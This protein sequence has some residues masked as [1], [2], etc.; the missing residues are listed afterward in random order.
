MQSI[1]QVFNVA[2]TKLTS[3]IEEKDFR[4]ESHRVFEEERRRRDLELQVWDEERRQRERDLLHQ[5][6]EARAMAAEE[7]MR[8]RELERTETSYL[9]D[10]VDLMERD[11]NMQFRAQERTREANN[12]ILS[13]ISTV[14]AVLG[15]F[16]MASLV[17]TPLE[18]ANAS[19]VLVS[20]VCMRACANGWGETGWIGGRV[21][22]SRVTGCLFG[23]ELRRE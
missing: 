9:L 4:E 10:K 21:C 23:E 5:Q 16:V 19:S 11:I 7:R 6:A 8:A 17:E 1:R 15:G 13:G 2:K 18:L 14:S 12:I 22:A 20:G 3:E